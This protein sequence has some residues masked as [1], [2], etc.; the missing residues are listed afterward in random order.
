MMFLSHFRNR[1]Y[2]WLL[3]GLACYI[4]FSLLTW[5]PVIVISGENY[6]LI[7]KKKNERNSYV[8]P[9]FIGD[10]FELEIPFII[11]LAWTKNNNKKLRINF[12]SSVITD[13]V[14]YKQKVNDNYLDEIAGIKINLLEYHNTTEGED[15]NLF[16]CNSLKNNEEYI[17]IDFSKKIASGDVL[18]VAGVCKLKDGTEINFNYEYSIKI[19]PFKMRISL[20]IF[21]GIP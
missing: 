17:E 5:G 9:T 18:R 4:I 20:C 7:E 10:Y 11:I 12:L 21:E 14:T 15:F 6:L 19:I 1:R 3:G 13:D 2:L 16:E 8:S